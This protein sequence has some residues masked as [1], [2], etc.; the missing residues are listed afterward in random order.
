MY[1]A[2][3]RRGLKFSQVASPRT[4]DSDPAL[5][6]G[7]YG[8]RLGMYRHADPHQGFAILRR[9]GARMKRGCAVFTSNV[10]GH[11]QRAGFPE[12]PIAECHGSIHHLQCSPGCTTEV[13]S[14]D[15]SHL[16]LP[17]GVALTA[18]VPNQPLKRR[19]SSCLDAP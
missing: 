8:H 15:I 3:G 5:A 6:W 14:A 12:C 13:W 4:F 2:L 18:S 17:G 1:P 10:D 7:F 9:W 16:R 11:F 19:P